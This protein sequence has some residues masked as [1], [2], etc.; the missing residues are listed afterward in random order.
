MIKLDNIKKIQ[1]IIKKYNNSIFR[2]KCVK[3]Y[4]NAKVNHNERRDD[5]N[6]FCLFAV[7]RQIAELVSFCVR[8]VDFP[9]LMQENF[10]FILIFRTLKILPRAK[11]YKVNFRYMADKKLFSKFLS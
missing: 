7:Y 3:A 6:E 4:F 8:K 10:K 5:K 1:N 9:A 2:I 11:R